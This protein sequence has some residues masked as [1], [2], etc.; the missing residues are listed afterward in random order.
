IIEHERQ[1]EHAH[2]DRSEQRIHTAV[3]AEA[4]EEVEG[5]NISSQVS[6]KRGDVEQGFKEADIVVEGRWF[7][8]SVHQGYIEPHAALA[9]FDAAGNV[10]I[11]NT[12]QGQF[13]IRDTVAR[14]LKL[15]I[16]KVRVVASEI[17]GGFGAKFGLLVPITV[18]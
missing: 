9:A 11:W 5:G 3:G 13:Y 8:A 1:D 7:S 15:P 10:F 2:V 17:G 12:T 16:S 14:M 6:F 4:E 18:L